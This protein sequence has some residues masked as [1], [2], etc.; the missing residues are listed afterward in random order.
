MKKGYLLSLTLFCISSTLLAQHDADKWHFGNMAGLDFSGGAPT[1][2]TN[3]A[4]A[5]GEGSASI[6]DPVTGDLLFYTDGRTVWNANNAVMPNGSGLMGGISSTQAALIVPKP[7]NSS[8]YY[9]FTTDEIGD[10]LGLRVSEVNMLLDGGNGDLISRNLPLKA[11][12][13]EKVAAVQEPES[14]NYWLVTHGWDDDAFY[15]FKVTAT[16]IDSA[17]VSHT[18]IV[19]SD[20]VI[21]NSYGQMKFNSCGD[22]LALAAGYL[23]KVEL[24]DFDALTG[25]V[26]NP[27]TIS[28]TDH[29]YGVEFSSN[30]DVLYVSTYQV[31]GT[32]LQYDLTL[33]STSAMVAAVKTIS[34]T[35]DIYP[36][37]RGPDGKI[38]VVKSYSQ[39]LGV[40]NAPNSVG[41]AACN[42]VDNGVDLDPSFMGA[43]SGIGLPNF[44]STFTGDGTVCLGSA[45]IKDGI[46]S[47]N[48]VFP[49]PSN[50]SFTFI[51]D[52]NYAELQITD[53]SGRLMESH[54]NVAIGMTFSFGDKYVPGVYFIK[55]SAKN[56][57]S[58]VLPI[59]KTN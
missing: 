25:I 48:S 24:F 34:T 21:Q 40:I 57:K 35:S 5:A 6:S 12:V 30:D 32:L 1:V 19:H 37:Q 53:A 33:S 55:V 22:R 8:G 23:D 26:S 2:I 3:S 50:D 15:A 20:D 7:G 13:A 11:P 36:L 16:G 54:S 42:Y 31:T 10:S 29:V 49:N 38:Y 51:S 28:Y 44:V 56:G 43:N 59:I 46:L 58:D 41:V 52:D 45:G 14:P 18:G 17:I 27:Q 9:I 47:A 39:F 4:M